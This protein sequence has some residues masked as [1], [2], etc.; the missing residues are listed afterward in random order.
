VE[1]A[2]R[3][4]RVNAVAPGLIDTP[5]TRE[6]FG[7]AARLEARVREKVPLGRAGT[8]EDVAE[9]VVFLASAEAAYITGETLV[10]DGG[11]LLR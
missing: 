9:A 11:W 8:P 2:P 10:V 3:H 6:L 5:M 4:L 1:L 7:D